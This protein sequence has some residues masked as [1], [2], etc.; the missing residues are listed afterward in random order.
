VHRD[1]REVFFREDGSMERKLPVWPCEVRP[2]DERQKGADDDGDEGDEEVSEADGA[3]VGGTM[4]GSV[5]P[6]MS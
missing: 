5:N 2:H 3:V 4:E 6:S 1:Q